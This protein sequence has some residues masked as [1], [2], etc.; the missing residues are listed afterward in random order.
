[1]PALSRAGG[2]SEVVTVP[3]PAPLPGWLLLAVPLAA[4][5]YLTIRAAGHRRR[6]WVCALILPGAFFLFELPPLAVVLEQDLACRDGG[7]LLRSDARWI[8]LGVTALALLGALGLLRTAAGEPADPGWRMPV[9]VLALMM[10]AVI[11]EVMVS[12]VR[13]EEYCNGDRGLLHIQAV[14][15][16]LLPLAALGL[17]ASSGRGRPA[18]GVRYVAAP[19]VLLLPVQVVTVAERLRDDPLAC[20]TSRSVGPANR[21]A[22]GFRSSITERGTVAADFTGDPSVDLAGVDASGTIRVLRNDGRGGLVAE[23]GVALPPGFSPVGAMVAGDVDGNGHPDLVV[24]GI[25]PPRP[26]GSPTRRW[27][28]VVVL[29][30]GNRL[31]SR[32]P[33]FR[34]GGEALYTLALGDLDGDGNVEVV[35]LERG[36]VIVLGDRNG[37]LQERSRLTAP[38]EA[39]DQFGQDRVALADVDGDGRTDVITSLSNS[40]IEASFVIVHRNRGP[41]GFSSSVVHTFDRYVDADAL[42]DFDGDGD[43]DI[44]ANGYRDRLHVLA[45]RGDGAFDAQVQRTDIWGSELVAVD[46]DADGRLDLVVS[47]DY[48]DQES[49]YPGELWARLNLGGWRFSEPQ[50][51]ATPRTLVV[52][53]DLNGDGR[54]DFV[55]D[56]GRDLAAVTSRP[57]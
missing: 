34:D 7:V 17:G 12:A 9:I 57:C 46:V 4:A 43:V 22:L 5:L 29:N 1:M 35:L 30:D 21:D 10:P 8:V 31:I 3:P 40:R 24:T 51:L 42:A 26:A 52:A 48:S 2:N 14:L 54:A 45:N 32:A 25:E 16:F 56:A 6:W 41:A 33:L 36:V 39:A 27:G 53:A 50:R 11:V 20:A 47:A 37:D 55:V 38:P 15:G 13:L 19:L 23:P 44:V 18:E 49:R 28:V